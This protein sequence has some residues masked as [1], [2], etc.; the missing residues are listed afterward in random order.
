LGGA[1]T[2][3]LRM[4]WV[5]GLQLSDQYWHNDKGSGGSGAPPDQYYHAKPNKIFDLSLGGFFDQA[6]PTPGVNNLTHYPAS[7]TVWF[8]LLDYVDGGAGDV[9]CSQQYQTSSL[10]MTEMVDLKGCQEDSSVSAGG[11]FPAC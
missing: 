2:I 4:D 7:G 9:I 5:W 11:A 1:G 8:K 3:W 10:F 6:L